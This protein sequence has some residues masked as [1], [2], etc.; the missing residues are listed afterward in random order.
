MSMKVGL[1]TG[2]GDCPGLNAVIR[3]IVRKGEVVHGD[4]LIGFLDASLPPEGVDKLERYTKKFGA[5][6][7]AQ[8]LPMMQKV[9][10]AEGIAF[11]TVPSVPAPKPA[12]VIAFPVREDIREDILRAAS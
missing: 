4:E 10:A 7:V 11:E 5:A 9:G 1:L 8:M 12:E 3:A 2:G 6:R